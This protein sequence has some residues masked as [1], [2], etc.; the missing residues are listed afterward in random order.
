MPVPAPLACL[1][2]TYRYELEPSISAWVGFG[3]EAA[4]AEA[5]QPPP[6]L[7]LAQ[8]SM[9]ELDQKKIGQKCLLA[10]CTKMDSSSAT[11]SEVTHGNAAN[12]HPTSG[13]QESARIFSAVS[14][15]TY[16]G[17]MEHSAALS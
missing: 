14:T 17:K 7:S 11:A 1:L 5:S 10:V 15:R 2:V 16:K 13:Q 6:H 8:A 3:H 12:A 9:G 4:L